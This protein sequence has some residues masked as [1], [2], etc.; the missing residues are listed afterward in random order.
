M[1]NSRLCKERMI[2]WSQMP[3]RLGSHT[4]H[5]PLARLSKWP[6]ARV[7]GPAEVS[8]T[9]TWGTWARQH[10]IIGSGD[11]GTNPEKACA[12]WIK[13]GRAVRMHY[14]KD[15]KKLRKD[16]TKKESFRYHQK[17]KGA[18]KARKTSSCLK[19]HE[20]AHKIA[21]ESKQKTQTRQQQQVKKQQISHWVG[22]SGKIL[23]VLYKN[24]SRTATNSSW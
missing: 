9:V 7:L 4:T 16:G 22:H 15:C 11:R 24:K 17:L 21:E 23:Y 2:W 3:K 6:P 19:R 13:H 10:R 12:L 18:E 1:S 8:G 14:I 5:P 20:Q